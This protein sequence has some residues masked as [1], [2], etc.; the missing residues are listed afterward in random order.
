MASFSQ[1]ENR[2][3]SFRNIRRLNLPMPGRVH[4]L[5]TV[6]LP[7]CG[8][9]AVACHSG[10]ER[11]TVMKFPLTPVPLSLSVFG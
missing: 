10:R 9:L 6:A 8:S 11:L 2:V 5:E 4:G 3:A 1:G 7:L